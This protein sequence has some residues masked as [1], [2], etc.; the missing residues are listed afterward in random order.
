[1]S[2][3]ATVP[4]TTFARRF[5]HFQD[6]AIRSKMIV[7]TNHDRIVGGYLSAT[8]LQNSE[9]L[10]ARERHILKVGELPD[11]VIVD[12]EAAEYGDEAQ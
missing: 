5:A 3:R 6:K 2:D 4:A 1:M 10:K 9:R 11:Q 8:E 12:I 7:V